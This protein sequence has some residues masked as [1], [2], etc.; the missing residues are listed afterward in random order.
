MN[1]SHGICQIILPFIKSFREENIQFLPLRERARAYRRES[2]ASSKT[3]AALATFTNLL[4]I[5]YRNEC[6]YSLL[7]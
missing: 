5:Q 4:I 2:K 3:V 1:K 6:V 7:N